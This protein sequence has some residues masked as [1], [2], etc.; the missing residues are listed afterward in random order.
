M[1]AFVA[2]ELPEAFA[3]EVAA[4]KPAPDS[5]FALL[6]RVGCAAE[7]TVF[8]GDSPYDMQ[9]AH[10]AG[11]KSALALWGSHNPELQADF[12]LNHPSELLQMAD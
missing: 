9:C 4:P 11:V 5:I 12:R 7:D 6:E 10:A 2:L 1:R 3:D 8:L